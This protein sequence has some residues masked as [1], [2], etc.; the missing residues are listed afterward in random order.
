[1]ASKD[2][3]WQ[4]KKGWKYKGGL[5]PTKDPQYRKD[6]E[7]LFKEHGNGW[8]WGWH[9]VPPR[10]RPLDLWDGKVF[11]PKP[12]KKTNGIFNFFKKT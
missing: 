8:W 12:R 10:Q 6:R 3:D 4:N 2:Y 7:K 11:Q 1:M 9:L 5:D